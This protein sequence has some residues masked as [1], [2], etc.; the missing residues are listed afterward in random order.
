MDTIRN[1]SGTD[2]EQERGSRYPMYG[3]IMADI[4]AHKNAGKQSSLDIGIEC[5]YPKEN[6]QKT[7]KICQ[8]IGGCPGQERYYY[9]FLKKNDQDHIICLD[10]E[11]W[12]ATS[13]KKMDD[14]QEYSCIR[15][16]K[17]KI[18]MVNGEKIRWEDLITGEI[19][20]VTWGSETK[21]AAPP[22]IQDML[23][24]ED[25]VILFDKDNLITKIWPDGRQHQVR[26]L[27]E[28]TYDR[29]GAMMEMDDKI[30]ILTDSM[31]WEYDKD[32]TS[33]R[34][35][36]ESFEKDEQ[37]SGIE[38]NNGRFYFYTSYSYD[39][40][41]YKYSKDGKI[42]KD[43]LLTKIY[44]DYD[45]PIEFTI[46]EIIMTKDYRLL[47]SHI[48]T[49]DWQSGLPHFSGIRLNLDKGLAAI[50]SQ[51]IFVG[52]QEMDPHNDTL[53]K[54]DPDNSEGVTTIPVTIS[55]QT[56]NHPTD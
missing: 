14:L 35:I 25:G 9:F 51:N 41:C 36:Y 55:D 23:I 53:L 54:I 33:K 6:V 3:R 28:Y 43:S 15:S 5:G 27:N 38:N 34:V 16:Q 44:L 24:I 46:Q 47:D 48:F 12:S 42:G 49:K 30:Y 8:S 29:E 37:I 45:D 11:N 7:I 52:V 50:Y 39:E 56:I 18:A 40:K 2:E 4:A 17:N 19:A 26:L 20:E 1:I 13:I 32:L 10:T 21:H 31:I 22:D